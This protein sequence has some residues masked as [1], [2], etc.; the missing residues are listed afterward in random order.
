MQRELK[1][2]TTFPFLLCLCLLIVNDSF[3]KDRYHNVLTGK[4]SDVCGLFIF[5]IFWT[6]LFPGRK[7]L[8]FFS[9]ALLFTLWKSPYSQAFINIFSNHIYAIHRVVDITDLYALLI[10]PIAWY[11]SS[12]PSKS[13]SFN[14]WAAAALTLFSF[15]ATSV[16]HSYQYFEQPQYVLFET[17]D[18]SLHSGSFEGETR[19]FRQNN[20]LAV[21]VTDIPIENHPAKEDDF[22]K[23]QVLKNLDKRLLDQLELNQRPLLKAPTGYHELT[24]EY[25]NYKDIA[26]FTGSRLHG[27]FYRYHVDGKLLI[28]GFYRDGLEDS[29]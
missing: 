16:P 28:E 12:S 13:M 17:S 25:D 14:P 5:P 6:A 9:T 26:S 1:R 24:L 20:L 2:L 22:Q 4:I 23:N 11:F 27:N 21:Q 29:V 15:C 10:L 7:L 19:L 18:T 3:L 8:I